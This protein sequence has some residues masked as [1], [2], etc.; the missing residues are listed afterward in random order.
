VRIAHVVTLVSA[1]G[2]FGG[3]LSV[4][5]GQIRELVRRGHTLTLYAGWD[6]VA[7]LDLPSSVDLR[8]HK[9]RSLTPG[10]SLSGMIAVKLPFDLD[11]NSD[12]H[13]IVHLHQGRDLMSVSAGWMANARG[14]PYLVQTHGMIGP[15]TRQKAKVLDALAVRRVLTGA[16]RVLSLNEEE[17]RA[18]DEVLPGIR[19]SRL[20]NG[21]GAAPDLPGPDPDARPIVLFCAR[22]S[23]R[24]RV[25]AFALLALDLLERGVDADFVAV[26]SDEGD[27]AEFLEFVESKGWS[28]RIRYEG[29]V[30]PANVRA[31]LAQATVFV[32]PSVDEPFPMTVLEALSVGTP[33]VVTDSCH[34]A[35]DLKARGAVSVSAP[36]AGALAEA[37]LDLLND[38][39]KRTA[40]GQAGRQAIA[41]AY[42]IGPVVDVLEHVYSVAVTLADQARPKV[43]ERRGWRRRS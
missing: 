19:T 29:A 17:D 33:T 22:L 24:K 4:A 37:V 15:D 26:G 39:G 14:L 42:G 23:R 11:A 16:A 2:S 7:T 20:R 18:L 9:V 43:T 36:P 30:A 34:I 32:L 1:D 28:E 38:S 5:V 10:G 8:L 35:A 31:K 27:L 41:D 13:D 25:L 6:G 21:I 3:P 12:A 40:M